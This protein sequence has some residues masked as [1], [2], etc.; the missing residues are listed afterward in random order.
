MHTVS[1]KSQHG[2]KGIFPGFR[3]F[4]WT[5]RPSSRLLVFVRLVKMRASS[6]YRFAIGV[7]AV[8]GAGHIYAAYTLGWADR[9]GDSDA[10]RLSKTVKKETT[11]GE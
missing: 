8:L 2:E 5:V 4:D 10:R 7:E 1:V 6:R 9:S 3:R 11:N